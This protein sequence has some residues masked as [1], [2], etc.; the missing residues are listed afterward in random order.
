MLGLSEALMKCEWPERSLARGGHG[1]RPQNKLSDGGDVN[2][3]RGGGGV[4]KNNDMQAKH[5][6]TSTHVFA[7]ARASRAGGRMDGG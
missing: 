2:N 6:S 4:E 1:P 5:C 3:M 7:G